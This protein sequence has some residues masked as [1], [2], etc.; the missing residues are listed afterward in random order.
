MK[1]SV[2]ILAVV[3]VGQ[4]WA[5]GWRGMRGDNAERTRVVDCRTSFPARADGRP[6][7]GAF[8]YDGGDL[9]CTE[10]GLVTATERL[11]DGWAYTWR[12]NLGVVTR[13]GSQ[14][15]RFADAM[16]FAV[17][18]FPS[19]PT[20]TWN[21]RIPGVRWPKRLG[22]GN[23]CPV[24]TVE[25]QFW[26]PDD[27]SDLMDRY[28]RQPATMDLKA[29]T[30]EVTLE[31]CGD[32]VYVRQQGVMT[33]SF[34]IDPKSFYSAPPQ[35]ALTSGVRFRGLVKRKL[36]DLGPYESVQMALQLNSTGVGGTRLVE[37]SAPPKGAR[38]HL[39]GVPFVWNARP[40][41]GPD[42]VDVGESWFFQHR[43]DIA[44]MPWFEARR[45]PE[46]G[47]RF[48]GRLVFSVP[49][50]AYDRLYVLAASDS[51]RPDAIDTFTVQFFG[52]NQ[53]GQPQNF[54][55]PSVPSFTA[56]PAKGVRVCEIPLEDG[57]TGY[58]HLV[59]VPLDFTKWRQFSDSGVLNF[60]ITKD[61]S[62][63]RMWPD[64]C[65]G[66]ENGAGLP[67][68]VH[69]FAM[70]LRRTDLPM[71]FKPTQLAGL[72]VEGEQ[73]GYDLTLSNAMARA[74][75]VVGSLEATSWDRLERK[76]LPVSVPL[77]AGQEKMMR[78]E[79]PLEKFGHFDVK[80]T[81]SKG[82]RTVTNVYARTLS[83]IRKRPREARDMTTRGFMFGFWP[84]LGS[85]D[86]TVGGH[87]T[88]SA[89]DQL[90]LAGRLGLE[91]TGCGSQLCL[92]YGTNAEIIAICRK[93]GIRNY[94][95]HTFRYNEFGQ[96]PG[97]D[98]IRRIEG[99]SLT[100]FNKCASGSTMLPKTATQDPRI[101]IF[102]AEPGGIGSEGV[103]GELYGEPNEPRTKTQAAEFYRLWFS[104]KSYVDAL[105]EYEKKSGVH[106]VKLLPWGD[107]A[108]GA[109]FLDE[110]PEP[111]FDQIDG[112]AFDAP[113]FGRLPE[114]QLSQNCSLF[115]AWMF[116]R[117]WHRRHPGADKKPW[118]VAM[119]G[120]FYA[121][122]GPKRCA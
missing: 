8:Q 38:F 63:W 53:T 45:W 43:L 23:L 72:F 73:P 101:Q 79:L 103:P 87:R 59:E 41:A 65:Y 122:Y 70:T 13:G 94:V 74:V 46:A 36:P 58:L 108:L 47:T 88:L 27:L 33:G 95:S 83:R 71:S 49:N 98:G 104:V 52:G 10:N 14:E 2:L 116:N 93:Y 60:E 77:A 26:W 56:K 28:N 40:G 115:R 64:P 37:K 48:P 32:T 120:P 6:V 11:Q 51:S 44:G 31:C 7:T 97:K 54:K 1:R 81:W 100:N 117:A 75:T 107:P 66:S 16:F 4:A 76:T 82:P 90:T 78:L 85:P 121:P 99:V 30:Y 35:L 29:E 25:R 21:Q 67:S 55:S 19:S 89:R 84:W 24:K 12:F 3:V 9:Y 111:E 109:P 105:N 113:L 18:I 39:N 20:W 112:T 86:G 80:L 119:E 17:G 92:P 42:N 15:I 50:A 34:A 22:S 61:V 57:K 114:A 118:N 62:P 5:G 96:Q 68:S 106:Q 69:I 102:F 110:R 91:T